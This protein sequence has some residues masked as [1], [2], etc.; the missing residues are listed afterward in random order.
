VLPACTQSYCIHI[1]LE[2]LNLPGKPE[3][4]K[5][6]NDLFMIDHDNQVNHKNHSSDIP[7]PALKIP[8]NNLHHVLVK[9][10]LIDVSIMRRA[11]KQQLARGA[12]AQ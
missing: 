11:R 2:V 8:F 3:R 6:N 9:N 4:N 12:R 10:W 5:G 1:A 7:F